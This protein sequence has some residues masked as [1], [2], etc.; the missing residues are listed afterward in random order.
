M[1]DHAMSEH[2]QLQLMSQAYRALWNEEEQHRINRDIQ[3]HRQTDAVFTLPRIPRGAE[4]QVEQT[5]HAF[6][7]G[8]HLF[9]FDQL[10]SDE[11]NKKYKA[12]YG[13]LFNAATVAFYWAPFEPQEGRMRFKGEA[14]DSAEFWNH[15]TDPARQPH[16]RRPAT[17]PVVEFCEEKGIHI[18]GHTLVWGNTQWQHPR[19]LLARLPKDVLIQMLTDTRNGNNLMSLG[20]EQIQQLLP[21][22][23]QQLHEHMNRRIRAIAA[24][25]D[26]RIHSWDVCNESATDFEH[27]NLIPG[28]RLC[29]SV[30]GLMPGDYAWQA[31]Q[32]AQ[33]AFPADVELHINDYN[34][35][36]C[37][38]AQVR[39]M[40][41]RGC[42]IDT[43][44][45]QMHLFSPQ[46]CLDIADGKTLIQSPA[47]VR[48]TMDRLATAGLPI[49]LSEI[50]IT[51]PT[52]DARGLAIQAVLARNLYR[53]WF[54]LKPMMGITWWNVVDGCGAP[55]EPSISGL[56]TQEMNPKPAYFALKQLIEEQWKT[57]TIVKADQ[58]GRIAFRGFRGSYHLTWHDNQGTQQTQRVSVVDAHGTTTG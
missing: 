20:A 58:D 23:T 37:Y 40:Q 9:N 12:L 3:A 33:D 29:R 15:V 25:Y 22:Y 27:G 14:Q 2:D 56:F 4:V 55:G 30:Y 36:A 57:R 5:S 17:D 21:D 39:D 45:A 52:P 42:R 44:G 50:T 53:L 32:I 43:L 16:W 18:H 51:S 46:A 13:T 48:E 7:F 28:Q 34:L 19:W 1:H 31:F 38:P 10:G 11:R 8:A 26:N 41:S 49:H 35:K 24:H 54:S 47:Q 6:R